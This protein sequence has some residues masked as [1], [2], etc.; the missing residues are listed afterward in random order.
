MRSSRRLPAAILAAGL[1]AVQGCAGGD[2]SAPAGDRP[3]V[4]VTTSML[5]AAV[6]AIPALE[7]DVSVTVLVPPGSCPGHFDLRPDQLTALGRAVAVLHPPYQA[8]LA[9]KL[10]AV[11]GHEGR[12]VEVP[13]EDSPLVPA[14][15]LRLVRATAGALEAARPGWSGDLV[16][17][18]GPVEA[19]LGSLARELR[20]RARPLA[21]VP[22][23]ASR[24]QAPFCRWLG[25]EVVAELPRNGDTAPAV[26]EA[27]LDPRVR[28]VVAN[29]Q[30]GT[31]GAR[32][33]AERLGVPV[34]E[35]SAFP[36]A[37]GY[38]DRY[39]DLL[40]TNLDHLERAW[41]DSGSS[42]RG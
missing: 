21:G 38:G 25:L 32:A 28:L 6:R 23:V 13:E 29:L 16:G 22:V 12:V 19:R 11:P 15:F 30:E 37:S 33:V 5:A 34:A 3:T 26:L 27:A 4:V 9:G 8:G 7:R 42:P 41:R 36:G 35:L 14:G 2:R 10:R 1:L 40:E 18:L 24:F 17:S 39:E 20:R 31:S